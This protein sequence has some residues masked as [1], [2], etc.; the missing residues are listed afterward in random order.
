MV[1]K[2]RWYHMAPVSELIGRATVYW[3]VYHVVVWHA[4]FL[5]RILQYR[6]EVIAG[7]RP[8]S[9]G[10]LYVEFLGEHSIF[11][12]C[13]VALLP[14]VLWDLVHQSR[15]IVGPLQRL[16]TTLRSMTRGESTQPLRWR[17]E[18]GHPQ[19][20]EA[21]NQFLEVWNQERR[22]ES[23]VPPPNHLS[24]NASA[25]PANSQAFE[26][27]HEVEAMQSH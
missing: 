12:W 24:Q 14:V 23:V 19:L 6:R 18:D 2:R 3:C 11:L 20:L 26:I 16:E 4:M 9:F 15:R 7:A 22:A 17:K 5:M 1:H 21:F 25:V 27:L 13:A 10:S 8:V